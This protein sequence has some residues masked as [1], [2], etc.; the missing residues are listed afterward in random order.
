MLELP[1]ANV[2]AIQPPQWVTD[3]LEA[4]ERLAAL[5]NVTRSDEEDPRGA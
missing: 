1:T 5:Q 2:T 3:L 4:G